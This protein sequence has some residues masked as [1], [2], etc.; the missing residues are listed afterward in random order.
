LGEEKNIGVTVSATWLESDRLTPQNE[1]EEWTINPFNDEIVPIENRFFHKELTRTRLGVSGTVEFRVNNENRFFLSANY[2][3][4]EDYEVR[5]RMRWQRYGSNVTLETSDRFSGEGIGRIRRQ[6]RENKMVQELLTV[7]LGGEHQIGNI[8]IDHQ[9]SYG[10]T[11]EDTPIRNERRFQSPNFL[12]RWDFSDPFYPD[13]ISLGIDPTGEYTDPDLLEPFDNFDP[14]NY[15]L[16]W[17]RDRAEF[18]SE[19]EWSW[20]GNMKYDLNFG[21][22]PGFIQGGVKLSLRDHEKRDARFVWGEFGRDV[23]MTEFV[24]SPTLE[25]DLGSGGVFQYGPKLS[26]DKVEAFQDA[27]IGNWSDFEFEN[28]DSFDA[29]E[30][31]IAVYLMA[32]VDLDKT[33]IQGGVRWEGNSST[34]S[35][36]FYQPNPVNPSPLGGS[37]DTT[38]SQFLPSIQV[39]YAASESLVILGSAGRSYGRPVIGLV[40]PNIS[41]D[42]SEERIAGGNPFLENYDS[43][44]FDLTAQY[45]FSNIGIVSAGVFYKKVDGYVYRRTAPVGSDVFDSIDPDT[46]EVIDRS[47]YLF[48]SFLNSESGNIT[49]LE[50]AFQRQFSELPAPFDGLGVDANYTL[51]SSSVDITYE[52]SSG[53]TGTREVPFFG[54]A[55]DVANLSF[56]YSKGKW[57]ARLSWNFRSPFLQDEVGNFAPGV[58]S[59]DTYHGEEDYLDFKIGYQINRHLNINAQVTNI[60]DQPNFEQF[61]TTDPRLRQL[62]RSGTFWRIG[63][64]WQL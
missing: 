48:S 2:A 54:Q 19:K 34:Y 8:D 12:T 7:R 55:D 10:Y 41:I 47:G 24:E 49:G 44:N 11:E 31:T 60:N 22:N 52:N 26:L 62:T 45:F 13:A 61:E 27:E 3:Q 18:S 29:L 42:D 1:A 35:L 56:Y 33:T 21:D 51:V 40:T 23:L 15:P 64:G 38:A 36:P 59:F 53:G 37:A 6:I 46:G 43:W 28:S 20:R 50:L 5:Q 58:P 16:A 63:L 39:R 17:W 4:I 32:G 30:D 57:E 9:F 25:I 14:D